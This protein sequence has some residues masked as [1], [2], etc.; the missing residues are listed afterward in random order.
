MAQ[1]MLTPE[2]VEAIKAAALEGT[3]GGGNAELTTVTLKY[4]HTTNSVQV[5][6]GEY[7]TFSYG[8]GEVEVTA[9]VAEDLLRRDAS[10]DQIEEYRMI[11]GDYTGKVSVGT[12]SAA[13]KAA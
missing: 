2:E 7:Q 3:P 4:K 8:P 6:P 11:G 12:I 10:Y 13:G 9:E 5:S 1:T